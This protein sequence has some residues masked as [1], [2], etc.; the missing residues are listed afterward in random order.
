MKFLKIALVSLPQYVLPQ[1]FLSRMM[2]W[3]TRCEIQWWKNFAIRNVISIYGVNLNEAKQEDFSAYPSFNHF[4]IRELKP[5]ARPIEQSDH[6]VISPADGAISQIGEINGTRI[7]Q[8]KG[9]QFNLDQLLGASPYGTAFQGGSF[10]TIYL[11]PR[12]YHRLHM[13]CRGTLIE[14]RY[15]PGRLFSVNQA[16]TAFVP[17]LFARNER[18]V[19]IFETSLGKLALVLVGAIFVSSI[20]TAW[21]GEVTPPKDGSLQTWDY[22]DNPMLL[23]QGQEMGRF[24]MG[25]T[26]IVLFEAGRVKWSRELNSGSPVKMGQRIGLTTIEAM[27]K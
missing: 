18:V 17:N 12:D 3:L 14:M 5:S 13:P 16:T 20:E 11:S 25:S 15:I 24:N 27:R 7:L 2:H 21:H 4:F 10:A 23:E 6:V 9:R 22:M 26:I 1:H 19:A 8:A